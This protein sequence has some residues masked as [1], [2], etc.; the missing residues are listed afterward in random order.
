MQIV[1]HFRDFGKWLL[2]FLFLAGTCPAEEHAHQVLLINSYHDSYPWSDEVSKSI[3]DTLT[4]GPLSVEF[5]NEYMDTKRFEPDMI[6]PVFASLLREKFQN[7]SFDVLILLDNNALDFYRAYGPKLFSSVPAVFCGINDFTPSMLAGLSGITG[8][9]EDADF[10]GTV[11]AIFK[12]QPDVET[13]AVVTDTV[14]TGRI[15]RKTFFEI[16][17]RYTHRVSFLDLHEMAAQDLLA[18]LS[19]LNPDRSAVLL[20]SYQKDPSGK[21]YSVKE[22]TRI[23]GRSGLPQYSCWEQ[24]LHPGVVGGIMVDA[25]THGRQTGRMVLEILKG[26][27][28]DEI[29]VEK[30]I[31]RGVFDFQQLSDFGLSPANLPERAR[32]VNG[33]DPFWRKYQNYLLIGTMVILLMAA[34]ILFLA[35]NILRRRRTQ[36]TLET[37]L[38]TLPDLV[39]IHDRYGKILFANPA[40]SR[41][42]GIRTAKTDTWSVF[43]LEAPAFSKTF[44]HRMDRLSERGIH[45]A[46][47]QYISQ[48]GAVYDV[49]IKTAQLMFD[50]RQAILSV[51][52]DISDIKKA[53]QALEQSSRMF[54]GTFEQAAVGIAHVSPD[55]DFLRI[56]RRF[57]DIVGYSPQ[58]MI[59]KTFQEITH[60][61]DLDADLAF[62]NQL[63]RGEIENYSMEKRYYHQQGHIVWVNLTVALMRK[64]DGNPEYMIS[65]AE[66]ISERKAAQKA[67]QESEARFRELFQNMDSAVVIYQAIEN[68]Q[69][70]IFK[71][72]NPAGE[73]IGHVI[74]EDHFGKRILDVYPGLK[75]SGLF[76][77]IQNVWETSNPKRIPITAYED[78]NLSLWIDSYICKIPTGE[79]VAVYNDITERKQAQQAL[80][81]SEQRFRNFV[82]LAPDPIFIHDRQGNIKIVNQA[83]CNA[84]GYSEAELTGMN[85]LELETTLRSAEDIHEVLDRVHA[86]KTQILYGEHRRKDGSTFPVEVNLACLGGEH[87]HLALALARDITEREKYQREIR[88]NEQRLNSIFKSAPVGIGM[89]INRVLFNLNDRLCEMVGYTSDELIGKSARILYP[90]QEDYDYVGREKYRQIKE[91]GTGSV[92][93]R[94]RKKTGEIINVILSSTPLDMDDWS[95]G[96]TFTALDITARKKME[97]ELRE[98]EQQLR[99]VFRSAPVGIG[100]ARD[101]IITHANERVCELTGYSQQELIGKDTRI[102]YPT[103]QEYEQIGKDHYHAIRETG[104]AQN[105]SRFQRKDGSIF[106]VLISS[107]R[108]DPR[109]PA[110][111]IT[112]TISDITELKR[113]E[114]QLRENEQLLQDTGRIARIGGWR[115]DAKTG[116]LRLTDQVLAIYELEPG[117]EVDVERA[118]SFYAPQS[119]PVIRQ[120]VKECLEKAKP[121]DLELEF[122]TASGRHLWVHTEGRAYRGDDGQIAYIGGT[123]QDVTDRVT[124]RKAIEESEEKYRLLFET[125]AEG[126]IIMGETVR[127][128]NQRSLEIFEISYQEMIGK[129]PDELSAPTQADGRSSTEVAEELI[130]RALSGETVTFDWKSKTAK[131]KLFDAIVALK[132]IVIHDEQLLIASVRDI[133][134]RKQAEREI[135]ETSRRLSNIL[136]SISD[137]FFAVNQ[138]MVLTYYNHA[139]EQILSTPRE[140]VIGKR[141]FE[142]C[143]TEAKGS[144]F[145][146]KYTQALREKQTVH[147]EA[148]FDQP[149]YENWYNVRVFPFENGI[150]V[151]FQ[152]T[153]EQKL[154]QAMIQES[155]QNYRTL[156]ESLQE[157]IWRLDEQ[158]CTTFVNPAM[159]EMLGYHPDEMIGRMPEDFIPAAEQEKLMAFKQRMHEGQAVRAESTYL[160]K[161]GHEVYVLINAAP[162]LDPDG[163]YRGALAAMTDISHRRQLES[164]R[165]SLMRSLELKN[166][167]LES[168]I[169]VASH[170]LR[171][172]LVNIQGFS[173]ELVTDFKEMLGVLSKIEIPLPQRAVLNENLLRNIP[174][175]LKYITMS[176]KKMDILLRGLLKVSRM[177]RATINIKSIDINTLIEEVIASLQYQINKTHADV[178][179]E[180]DLPRCRA[181]YTQLTHVF[182]NLIDNAVKYLDTSRP[183]RIEIS[184][185]AEDSMVVYCIRDNGIGISEKHQDRI[186]EIFHRLDPSGPVAGE[187]L[188]LTIVKRV[189]D[190]LGGDIS[191]ES[192]PGNG[193]AFYISLPRG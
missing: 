110:R 18:A 4:A 82:Q 125:S 6:F 98:S 118:I 84:L 14:G 42:L 27:A 150:S 161:K 74:R 108:L 106:D 135:R 52:R 44:A 173:T 179:V 128:A 191:L 137:G 92:E 143:F 146:Q 72:I 151:Y 39:L 75:E 37:I 131:G 121:F 51:A 95:K 49:D 171:S 81:E 45:S 13:I 154:A 77:A 156:V 25:R 157:G 10:S 55:G 163:R 126:V 89:V 66:D 70:F 168:I 26:R 140:E 181:D 57:C 53:Q 60:P 73:K 94:F 175:S 47:G 38:N 46:Q 20:L 115:V 155:E 33:P 184:G 133:T 34:L 41:Q 114:Q 102:L 132:P 170:D 127:D 182:T 28:A 85:I 178:I 111:G 145:E 141:L 116:Q 183:G 24:Y 164:Q 97:D 9:S 186:F 65:V 147:F 109:D 130:G 67:L 62:V 43:D 69:D 59:N 17:P 189:I 56:N 54:Q 180:P 142:D 104:V 87:P 134:A 96:V 152:V 64:P 1:I 30:S 68:G 122:I 158:D 79:I 149:P 162:Y 176:V 129:K 35:V 76:D 148:Y 193:T 160:H 80:E 112:F 36:Q 138:D 165:E 136:E 166:Q 107:A 167:E 113:A 3:L 185:A 23:I 58:E 83:A 22:A 2:I 172:P 101:R 187:G 78:Q 123:F 103:Q 119:V 91:K 93:T 63:L 7:H 16:A 124:A 188:G 105:E 21:T 153:T 40:V 19:E 100:Q 61:E 11:E 15:H 32:L 120:G 159:A 8:I 90:T 31:S 192:I 29:P 12:L 190:R 5:H 144:L 71:D 86:Q 48:A 88:E 50:S 99:S 177:G 174:D 169:Y 139:A 117:E